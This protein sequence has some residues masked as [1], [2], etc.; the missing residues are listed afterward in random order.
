[1][2]SFRT[3]HPQWTPPSTPPTRAWRIPSQPPTSLSP[4]LLHPWWACPTRSR[5]FTTSKWHERNRTYLNI[6]PLK[7]FP[8]LQVKTMII[9]PRHLFFSFL[10]SSQMQEMSKTRLFLSSPKTPFFDNIFF[11]SPFVINL[12]MLLWTKPDCDWSRP[13]CI[14][15]SCNY[16]KLDL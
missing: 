1:M 5:R 16:S 4:L 7:Y 8:P 3:W 11:L 14:W 2:F 10:P 6:H 9:S 15:I 12:L 13:S